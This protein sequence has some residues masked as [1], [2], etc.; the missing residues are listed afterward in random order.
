MSSRRAVRVIGDIGVLHNAH[1]CYF[2]ELCV[3]IAVE[4]GRGKMMCTSATTCGAESTTHSKILGNGQAK[5]LALDRE[6][7][8]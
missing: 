8:N 4:H 1:E 6:I 5:N 2:I 7:D 3:L